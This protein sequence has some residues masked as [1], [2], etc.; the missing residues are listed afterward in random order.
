MA[1]RRVVVTGIGVVS[2]LGLTAEE[3]W[4]SACRG[5]NGV[6]PITQFD[7][8]TYPVR[9]A[10]EV[11]GFSVDSFVEQR[12]TRSLLCRGAQFGLAAAKMAWQDAGLPAD[13]DLTRAGVIAGSCLAAPDLQESGS[14]CRALT[15]G[16]QPENMMEPPLAFLRRTPHAAA[17]LIAAELGLRGPVVSVY[18]A[19]A[20]ATQ[21]MGMSLVALRRGEVDVVVSGGYDALVNEWFMLCFANINALSTRN[22]DPAHASRPFDKDR[23]GF[24]MGEGA[25]ILILEELGHARRR[26]ATIYA[27]L[28]GAGNSLDAFRITDS[29]PDG[30]GA[31]EAM[32]RALTDA[33]V[34][35]EEVDY[36]NAHGTS[37]RDNDISETRA[38]K[39]TFGAYAQRVLI[40]STKSMTGHLISAAGGLEGALAVMA[41][42]DGVVPPTI[43]H[44]E[45]DPECDLDYVPREARRSRLRTAMSNSFGFGGSNGSVVLR[46]WETEDARVPRA[47]L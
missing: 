13:T 15:D 29:P 5:R 34:R 7:A 46:R 26:G 33:G 8:S 31:A 44:D 45:P 39:S 22:D 42:R 35:P 24:V 16:V 10:A 27:E 37:T 6:A 17:S 41:L 43:N 11:K 14:L 19:C 18:V 38:I 40:S 47:I 36:I 4:E 21:A 32:R 1:E 2:P 9:F 23:D 12:R 30:A 28:L 25:G 3:T 20:S